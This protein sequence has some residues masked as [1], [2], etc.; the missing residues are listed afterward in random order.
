[1]HNCVDTLIGNHREEKIFA[2]TDAI[3][4]QDAATALRCWEQV[5]ATDRAA[6][7]RAIAGLAWGVRRLLEARRDWEAGGNIRELA[8]RM[9][10]DPGVLRSRLERV[11]TEQLEA[12]QRDLLAADLAVKTGASTAASAVEKFIITHSRSPLARAESA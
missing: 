11:T 10:T 3:S 7:G 1:M 8:R 2:V 9:Y 12:Q 6:P 4:S 5:L